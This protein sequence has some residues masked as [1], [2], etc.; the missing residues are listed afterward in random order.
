VSTRIV[1]G[2]IQ[3][4]GAENRFYTAWVIARTLNVLHDSVTQNIPEIKRGGRRIGAG[5]PKGSGRYGEPTVP[6]RGP[7]SKVR[8]ALHIIEG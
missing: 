7:K 1:P 2:C 5:R 8:R 6:V 3:F 4:L